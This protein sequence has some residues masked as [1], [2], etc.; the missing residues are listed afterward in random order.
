MPLCL[1]PPVFSSFAKLVF[2]HSLQMSFS[3]TQQ[4]THGPQLCGPY[5]PAGRSHARHRGITARLK[6][7]P[8][9]R[10]SHLAE[11]PYL[12]QQ[13][14][15]GVPDPAQTIPEDGQAIAS[16]P[17]PAK[18]DFP[19]APSATGRDAFDPRMITRSGNVDVGNGSLAGASSYPWAVARAGSIASLPPDRKERRRKEG[20]RESAL[21]GGLEADTEGGA[22]TAMPHEPLSGLLW[23]AGVPDVQESQ[24]GDQ[25]TGPLA[26]TWENGQVTGKEPNL[27]PAGSTLDYSPLSREQTLALADAR[28]DAPALFSGHPLASAAV[29]ADAPVPA[30]VTTPQGLSGDADQTSL[31]GL[32]GNF[33]KNNTP[34]LSSELENQRAT[35]SAAVDAPFPGQ[36]ILATDQ[37][38]PEV[39]SISLSNTVLALQETPSTLGVVELEVPVTLIPFDDISS[40]PGSL[41]GDAGLGSGSAAPSPRI[42]Q[43]SKPLTDLGLA[44]ASSSTSTEAEP[45]GWAS[46]SHRE[47]PIAYTPETLPGSP[48]DAFSSPAVAAEPQA[49]SMDPSDGAPG[50]LPGSPAISAFQGSVPAMPASQ[51][52]GTATS[53]SQGSRPSTSASQG[54]SPAMSASQG[55]G[56][57]TSAVQGPNSALAPDHLKVLPLPY[58]LTFASAPFCRLTNGLP[59]RVEILGVYEPFRAD[60][61]I[62]LPLLTI[63]TD[64][65]AMF[66]EQYLM[67]RLLTREGVE[68]A[69]VP[70]RSFAH[71]NAHSVPMNFAHHYCSLDNSTDSYETLGAV[72]LVHPVLNCPPVALKPSVSPIVAHL[73]AQLPHEIFPLRCAIS[74][75]ASPRW[76]SLCGAQSLY[77]LPP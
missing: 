11:D 25:Q 20:G 48:L 73:Q 63:Q 9:S 72:Q 52:S 5:N 27:A 35:I 54:S 1:S 34:T 74:F 76:C 32:P 41:R 13:P 61:K 44:H 66:F 18:Q 62:V 43:P 17:F 2:A 67:C 55:S 7:K 3:C 75:S 47:V 31:D 60:G 21:H 71:L 23:S 68:V 51:G 8:H 58:S 49:R 30:A 39:P 12:Q 6:L 69:M 64:F 46:H 50:P 16:N 10:S 36:H 59:W 42:S 26:E 65:A 77:L 19:D 22:R 4:W 33:A 45:P 24:Q 15:A 28:A 29:R 53:A 38:S 14:L 70:A 56:S 57:A 40:A 37:T